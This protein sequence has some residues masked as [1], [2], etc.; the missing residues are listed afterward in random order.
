MNLKTRIKELA[1]KSGD[2]IQF[3]S[4]APAQ[5]AAFVVGKVRDQF[6]LG[7]TKS[8]I[9]ALQRRGGSNINKLDRKA[10]A[11]MVRENRNNE[12]VMHGYRGKVI[13]IG[14]L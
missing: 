8:D 11:K 2:L 9:A 7:L 10:L 5:R 14:S 6:A 13:N 12:A 3:A 1:A 4:S